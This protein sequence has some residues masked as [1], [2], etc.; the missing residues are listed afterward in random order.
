MPNKRDKSAAN[1]KG[2]DSMPPSKFKKKRAKVTSKVASVGADL[3]VGE[4]TSTKMGDLLGPIASILE[5]LVVAE[6]LLE[7]VIPPQDKEET[8]KLDINQEISRLFAG[9]SQVIFLSD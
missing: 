5:N 8:E 2:K 4:G 3:A 9:V 6:K 7:G 1:S